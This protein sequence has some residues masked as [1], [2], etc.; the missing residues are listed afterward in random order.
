[1]LYNAMLS[2]RVFFDLQ[3]FEEVWTERFKSVPKVKND[4]QENASQM[5]D[6]ERLKPF[7]DLELID[8][9]TEGG[10]YKHDEA[11]Q[12]E[13]G[14]VYSLNLMKYER[15]MYQDRYTHNYK[16]LTSNQDG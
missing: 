4:T 7:S 1:M 16:L 8:G 2:Q 15:A 5:A 3:A 13:L 6:V 9:L 10:T 14:F 12:L 11:F